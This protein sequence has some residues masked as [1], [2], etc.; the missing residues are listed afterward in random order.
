[1]K[2]KIIFNLKYFF[3]I[4]KLEL[5]EFGLNQKGKQ[6]KGWYNI[7]KGRHANLGGGERKAWGKIKVNLRQTGPNHH[8]YATQEGRRYRDDLNDAVEAQLQPP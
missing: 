6:L 2:L 5:R 3:Q 7:F 8:A 4:K 1:M